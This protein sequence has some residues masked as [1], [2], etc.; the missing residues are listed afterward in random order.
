MLLVACEMGFNSLW[1]AVGY[2]FTQYFDKGTL[3]A[4]AINHSVLV[5]MGW[6]SV[7]LLVWS[8]IMTRVFLHMSAKTPLWYV[9]QTCHIGMYLVYCTLFTQFFGENTI[10]VGLNLSGGVILGL[11]LLDRMLMLIAF[12]LSISSFVLI[13]INRKF[14]WM[15]FETIYANNGLSDYWFWVFSH[16]YFAVT[17]VVVTILAVDWILKI[18]AHQQRKIYELSQRDSLTGLYNRRTLYCYLRFIWFQQVECQCLSLLYFDIDKFK[19][20]NDQYGHNTGDKTL[21]KLG[22]VVSAVLKKSVKTSYLFGRLGG[23]EFVIALPNICTK[24]AQAL[25]EILREAIKA[26]SLTDKTGERHFF[27][28]ASFGVVTLSDPTFDMHKGD[29]RYQFD[30]YGFE[31]YLK[32]D[33]QVTPELPPS[34]QALI[35]LGSS[36]MLIA[37]QQ[38]RDR[39]VNGGIIFTKSTETNKALD[40]ALLH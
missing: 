11:L 7:A 19:E 35:N 2:G 8:L 32:N 37:K 17:K 27:A 21:V 33:L 5:L 25:A 18:L 15:P 3:Q 20:I 23:E 29:A 4:V 26:Y 16:M 10:V 36:S 34:I 6:A 24:E 28:T 39:V 12:A 9:S 40:N 31:D 22:E 38:G 13:G 14:Q 1:Y 30:C